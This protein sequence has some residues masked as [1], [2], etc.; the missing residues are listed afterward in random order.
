MDPVV[1][2]S[3]GGRFPVNGL[4]E[5]DRCALQDHHRYQEFA[6]ELRMLRKVQD[7]YGRHPNAEGRIKPHCTRL[8]ESRDPEVLERLCA[9][10][11]M[12]QIGLPPEQLPE[13]WVCGQEDREV[14]EYLRH[15]DFSLGPRLKF[16]SQ[17]V[18]RLQG[19]VRAVLCPRCQAGR[20][21][22]AAEDWDEFTA[23]DAIVWHWPHWHSLDTDGT[24]HVK[25]SG[26]QGGDHWTGEQ[27]IGRAEPEYDFWRWLV[28]QREYHRLVEESELPAIREQWSRQTRR[29]T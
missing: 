21:Q 9:G 27:A 20:L 19:S 22:V 26:W 6:E 1:C 29:G 23:R 11:P 18:V 15:N 8:L 17:E 13:A 24:L 25:A 10:I 3:C 5:D 12:D 28:A 7:Y 16:V 4:T 2:D 14:V